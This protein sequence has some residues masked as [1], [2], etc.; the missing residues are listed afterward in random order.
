MTSPGQ[1]AI[2]PAS[3]SVPGLATHTRTDSGLRSE[4][5]FD[6]EGGG[7]KVVMQEGILQLNK[8]HIKVNATPAISSPH[9]L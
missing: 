3:A 6:S 9:C 5:F 7:D 1:P 8:P 4:Y 2:A